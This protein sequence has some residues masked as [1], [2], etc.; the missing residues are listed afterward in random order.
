MK[1]DFEDK[2]CPPGC[3]FKHFS[4]FPVEGAQKDRFFCTLYQKQLRKRFIKGHD[5]VYKCTECQYEL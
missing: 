3:R 5:R 1:P 4:I 2:I